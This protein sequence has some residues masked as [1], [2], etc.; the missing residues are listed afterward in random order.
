[1]TDILARPIDAAEAKILAHYA[2]GETSRQIVAETGESM[3]DVGYVL[4]ALAGNSRE[5]AHALVL[6]YAERNG[7]TV[8]TEPPAKATGRPKPAPPKQQVTPAKLVEPIA[9]MPAEPEPTAQEPE[10]LVIDVIDLLDLAIATGEKSLADPAIQVRAQIRELQLAV[11]E[12][13]KMRA[14]V[15]AALTDEAERLQARVDEI[16][17]QLAGMDKVA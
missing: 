14:E 9:E 2:S 16:H 1:M 13:M 17:A 6:E 7:S 10:Q 15:R 11:H 5:R 12:H 4:D 3:E 8:T